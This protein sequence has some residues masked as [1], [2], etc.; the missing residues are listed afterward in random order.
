MLRCIPLPEHK[1]LTQ[2]RL[3]SSSDS[4]NLDHDLNRLTISKTTVYVLVYM[5]VYQAL[6]TITTA[7]HKYVQEHKGLAYPHMLTSNLPPTHT[8]SSHTDPTTPT[9]THPHPHPHTHPHGHTHT[10]T[11]THTRTHTHTHTPPDLHCKEY[12]HC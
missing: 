1:K 3:H 5:C 10:H 12:P 6:G 7:Q 8:H 2:M 4:N 9:P 11:P